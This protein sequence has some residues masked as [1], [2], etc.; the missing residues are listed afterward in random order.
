MNGNSFIGV[1]RDVD[2]NPDYGVAVAVQLGEKFDGGEFVVYKDGE[3]PNVVKR[4][5]GTVIVS[6]CEVP[7]EVRKVTVGERLSPLYFYSGNDSVNRR[8]NA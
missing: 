7:H 5:Y 3:E 4:T 8:R 2:T 1:H 6:K